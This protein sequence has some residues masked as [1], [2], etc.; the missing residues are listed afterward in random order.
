MTWLLFVLLWLRAHLADC[1]G[2]DCLGQ[3]FRTFSYWEGVVLAIWSVHC[4]NQM[5][6]DL[7]LSLLTAKCVVAKLTEYSMTSGV[8]KDALQIILSWFSTLTLV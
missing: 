6:H 4:V 7:T 2:G 1:L 3:T 8:I 5:S